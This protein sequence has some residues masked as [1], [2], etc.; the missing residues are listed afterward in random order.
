MA[1]DG[2]K[3]KPIAAYDC[4]PDDEDAAS[5]ATSAGSHK[6]PCG[7]T[8][9][10]VRGTLRVWELNGASLGALAEVLD[11]D[12]EILDR[13]GVMGRFNIHLEYSLAPDNV[14]NPGPSVFDALRQQLGLTLV[15]TKGPHE[16]LI[17]E[18]AARPE[19]ER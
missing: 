10:R 18:R 16:Y 14:E 1:K 4:A 11:T 12:R 17:V 15:S 19:V 3:I 2:L 8:A 5:Q 6:G 13:T 7:M 9:G